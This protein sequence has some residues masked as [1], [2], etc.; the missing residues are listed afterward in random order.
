MICSLICMGYFILQKMHHRSGVAN[1]EVYY[2]AA[3]KLLNNEEFYGVSLDG[4]EGYYKY[5]PVCTIVFVP[6]TFLPYGIANAIYYFLVLAAFITFTLFV[7][8]WLEIELKAIPKSLGWLI[9]LVNIF[10]VDHFEREL[11][12]GN[13][14]VFL[15]VG[16]FFVYVLLQKQKWIW[17]GVLNGFLL[18]FQPW[19]GL[20]S[21]FFLIKG[22]WKMVLLSLG[23]FG[24]GLLL[25]V[26][27]LGV[28]KNAELLHSWYS[29]YMNP[30]TVLADSPNTFYGIYNMWLL[31][32]FGYHSG[33][34]LVLTF[35]F[36]SFLLIFWFHKRNQYYANS[37]WSTFV[38]LS[39]V[40]ALIPNLIHTDTEHFMWV[41]PLLVFIFWQLQNLTTSRRLLWSIPLV[42]VFIPFVVNSPDI[43]GRKWMLIFDEGGFLGMANLVIILT[44]IGLF[45]FEFKEHE[46]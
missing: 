37:K 9:F 13:V 43:V 35:L 21:L 36:T 46:I 25:P 26:L 18:L 41:W 15:H 38:E 16:F 5:A 29:F 19:Y 23:V 1:F 10:L 30:S 22:K 11:H 45:M 8:Y 24:I 2:K 34:T 40:L 33:W 17:A 7:I 3:D 28:S 6:F 12:L 14:N 31:A 44:A 32:P 27:F 42:L 20:V 4:G 39:I